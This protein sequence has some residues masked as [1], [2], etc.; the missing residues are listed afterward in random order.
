MER[1]LPFDNIVITLLNIALERGIKKEP[2]VIITFGF[3]YQPLTFI[4]T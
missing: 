2:K 4:L 3:H 1:L